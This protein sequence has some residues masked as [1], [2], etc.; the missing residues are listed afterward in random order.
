MEW[1][2]LSPNGAWSF[3]FIVWFFGAVAG[4]C[5]GRAHAAWLHID[6]LFD[7]VAVSVE[8]LNKGKK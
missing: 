1:L 4:Y 7:D 5:F 3:A 2:Q 6:K 8:K